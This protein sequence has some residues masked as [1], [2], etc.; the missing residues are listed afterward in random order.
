MFPLK[1]LKTMGLMPLGRF[2]TTY[3]SDYKPLSERH[4]QVN[5][6]K[7]RPETK[8]A[9]PYVN[10]P[11]TGFHDY[12]YKTTNSNYGS[13][14]CS[15]P[16]PCSLFPASLP[17]FGILARSVSEASGVVGS[18]LT[19]ART[20]EV[21][22]AR[23]TGPVLGKEERGQLRYVCGRKANELEQQEAKDEALQKTD[24]LY[25][26]G[27]IVLSSHVSA[28]CCE[29]LLGYVCR[30]AGLQHLLHLPVASSP[31]ITIEEAEKWDNSTCLR[32]L[33]HAVGLNSSPFL[34]PTSRQCSCYALETECPNSCYFKMQTFPPATPRGSTIP[35][36]H[37]QPT[38]YSTEP[39]R[40]PQL[41][42]YQARY[43]VEWAQPKIQQTDFHHDRPA[44]HQKLYLSL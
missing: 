13:G 8:V 2:V 22:V 38:V 9:P 5:Q 19:E 36:A 24:V 17:P 11:Q 30:E 41:T 10:P 29:D 35:L 34:Q 27:V 43:T 39:R 25:E 40:T 16:L 44:R 15:Q 6:L 23:D 31:I 14:G 26:E 20:Q 42:E 4:P 3:S 18:A 28:A 21:G 12:F 33:R 37:V 7:P 32:G 1:R